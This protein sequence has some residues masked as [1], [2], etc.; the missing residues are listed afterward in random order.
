MTMQLGAGALAFAGELDA[1]GDI[2]A[3]AS[4]FEAAAATVGM[5]ASAC[6]MVSGP[7]ALSAEP[8]HFINWPADWLRLYQERGFVKIDA[9]PR[10]A[11]VSGAPVAWS[12]LMPTLPRNDPGRIVHAEVA[13]WGFREGYVTPVR[14][15]EGH[16]GLVSVAGPRRALAPAEKLYLQAV[17]SATLHR[18]QALTPDRQ[19]SDNDAFTLRERESIALLSQ[20]FTDRE[21]GK[22]LGISALTVHSHV[23]NARAKV[24]ARSRAHLVA[25]TGGAALPKT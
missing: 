24:G 18:A 5:S 2:A 10:W 23:Y 4:L 9:V 8:F 11:M 1:C 14:S 15:R 22:V 19:T 16:L 21:I 17:S 20:G 13:K 3:V 6:G 25:I 12:E 7:K